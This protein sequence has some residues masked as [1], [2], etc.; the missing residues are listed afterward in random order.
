MLSPRVALISAQMRTE[1]PRTCFCAWLGI[2][3]LSIITN[4]FNMKATRADKR[5]LNPEMQVN[6]AAN[7]GL[8]NI[9]RYARSHHRPSIGAAC[10]E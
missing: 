10:D 7:G 6:T 2:L 4:H 8:V 3:S 5:A 1:M 9:Q